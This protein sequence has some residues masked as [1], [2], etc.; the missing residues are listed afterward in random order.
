MAFSDAV[1]HD[2]LVNV[3]D[4]DLD[5]A[6]CSESEDDAESGGVTAPGGGEVFISIGRRFSSLT[7]SDGGVGGGGEKGMVIMMARAT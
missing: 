3:G 6:R 1:F 7:A 2:D 5:L 4:L